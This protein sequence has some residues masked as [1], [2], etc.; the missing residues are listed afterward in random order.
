MAQG[1]LYFELTD[2]PYASG[3]IVSAQMICFLLYLP[4]R[5]TNVPTA[6][7]RQEATRS[8]IAATPEWGNMCRPLMEGR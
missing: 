7:N 3:M 1:S 8:Y 2:G 4:S 6:W 5:L